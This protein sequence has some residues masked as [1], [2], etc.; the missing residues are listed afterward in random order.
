MDLQ[1]IM[2]HTLVCLKMDILMQLMVLMDV[3]EILRKLM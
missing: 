2:V 3:T 1:I